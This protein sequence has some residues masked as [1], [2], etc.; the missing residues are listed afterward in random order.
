[1]G[2]FL[3]KRR[4]GPR[5]QTAAASLTGCDVRIAATCA[6][7]AETCKRCH[8]HGANLLRL[9]TLPDLRAQGCTHDDW[10]VFQLRPRH[11]LANTAR[12]ILLCATRNCCP[13]LSERLS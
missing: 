1:M 12:S 3:S 5:L 13:V 9:S 6:I 8:G 4:L 10:R 11:P 2:G 7:S